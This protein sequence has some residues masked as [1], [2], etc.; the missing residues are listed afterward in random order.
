M[1]KIFE[2]YLS[3]E[4]Y[5]KMIRGLIIEKDLK[6]KIKIYQDLS[7]QGVVS[8]LE[9]HQAFVSIYHNNH[10]PRNLRHRKNRYKPNQQ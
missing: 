3:M 6:E 2:R 9:A 10:L 5:E 8:L 7:D 4:K 1:M